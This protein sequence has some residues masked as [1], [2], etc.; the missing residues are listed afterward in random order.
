MKVLSA[1]NQSW[2]QSSS[3]QLIS[4]LVPMANVYQWTAFVMENG[5]VFTAKTK[6]RSAKPLLLPPQ[7]NVTKISSCVAM[8]NVLL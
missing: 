4:S 5:T 1:L 8:E 2:I 7:R 3:A 6:Q